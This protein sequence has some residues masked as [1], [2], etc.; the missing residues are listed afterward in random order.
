MNVIKTIFL[1][2]LLTGLFLLVGDLIGGR[3]GMYGAL[4]LAAVMNLASYWFSDKV[5]LAM[6]HAQPVDPSSAPQLYQI[7]EGLAQRD[8][9]PTPKIYI[10]PSESP[11][12]FATGRDPQHAVVAVTQGIM[13]LLNRDELEG[14]ISHELSHVKNRDLLIGAMAATLA[15]ALMLLVRIFAFSTFFYGGYGGGGRDR[16]G[17]GLELLA[18]LII[19]PIAAIMIQMAIS[20]SREYQADASGAQLSG[21]PMGLAK[22]LAKLE[23]G[24][25]MRPMNAQPSTAHLFIVNPINGKFMAGLFSTHPPLEDRIARL[26]Q[27]AREGVNH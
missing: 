1:M 6:Y 20:R 2:G 25:A 16:G 8:N 21:N 9:L 10:I 12:A 11:N 5:V 18:M 14:V 15:G 7:V 23:Q 22:A 3:I 13:R 24:V 4:G 17:S 26:Q 19:G 27:M